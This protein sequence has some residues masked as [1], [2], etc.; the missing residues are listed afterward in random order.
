MNRRR[1]LLLALAAGLANP[2]RVPAQPTG[3]TA[4]RFRI[5]CL[6]VGSEASAKPLVEALLAGLRDFGYI[7][8]RNLVV[9]MRYARGDTSRLPAL[10][11]ELIALKPDV[12]VGIELS[13]TVMREKTTTIPIVLMASV[14]PVSAGLVQSLARSGTNVTGMAY[15][16]NEL[17][18]KH[19]ELLTEIVPKMSR[20]ALFSY[21]V[22]PNDPI[23]VA[24]IA[25]GNEEAAKAAAMRMGLILIV[26][27]ARDAD[28]VRRAFGELAKVRAEAIVVSAG[29]VASHLRREI[30]GE[31]R[32]LRLPSVTSLD[33]EWVEAGG[34]MSYGPA[35]LESYRYAATFVDR[36]LKGANPAELPLEQ[37]AK[38][39][40]L[41]NAK[42]AR[43]IGVTFPSSIL[44]RADRVIE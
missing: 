2:L 41:V 4:R 8:G 23:A 25:A 24:R 16:M 36:I 26:V 5:G 20:V 38:F 11:D 37:P 14:D 31:A 13:S 33:S 6:W 32:R 10:A 7:A 30:I 27:R 40:F 19:I 28:G 29:P 39:E 1:G 35:F 22:S 44:L 12:L 43:E 9:D 3:Q 18:A 17:V 42:T 21:A 34:L 15:R